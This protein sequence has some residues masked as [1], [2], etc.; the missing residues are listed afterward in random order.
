VEAATG[1]SK[2]VLLDDVAI[3]A[4]NLADLVSRLRAGSGGMIVTPNVDH[5]YR[6]GRDP[7]WR[8][9]LARADVTV[10][11]GMPLLW[12]A[13]L[14]GTPL[15]CRLSGSDLMATLAG[16]AAEDGWGL[17]L[18]GGAGDAAARAGQALVR[19]HPSLRLVG[20]EAPLVGPDGV[21]DDDGLFDR[22]AATSPR[23]VMVGLGSPKQEHFIELAL[24]AWP[25]AWYIG[26]GVGFGFLA[27][28]V[29]RAPLWMQRCG[30]EWCHRLSQEPRHLALRYARNAP[31][32]LG[33]L[34]RSLARRFSRA[35]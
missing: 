20:C 15:P 30:L 4:I 1:M 8:A 2:R 33:L 34:G 23:L 27:G 6:A 7:A 13:R 31:Y 12:A 5:L 17:C 26:V 14:A 35:R 19:M 28:Q 32:A 3:D 29:R 16:V 10:A 25:S 18:I 11:D 22:L 24:R 21:P 9:L